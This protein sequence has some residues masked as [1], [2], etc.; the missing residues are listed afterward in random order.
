MNNR[1]DV[2]FSSALILGLSSMLGCGSDMPFDVVSVHGKV[3]YDD[4]SLIQADSIHVTFNPIDADRKG[5]IV[6]PG[7]QTDINVQD[8]TFSA[9][10]SHRANDGLV[11][12]RHKVVV[13]AFK[14]GTDGNSVPTPAVPAIYRQV[15]TTPLEVEVDSPNQIL[16]LKVSKK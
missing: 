6:P 7:G 2:R 10:S 14:K 3:T 16:E 1:S 8:G 4:G 9:V 5:K 12:G 15:T 11:V 13:V